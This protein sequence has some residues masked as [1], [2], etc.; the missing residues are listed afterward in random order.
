MPE[1][2]SEEIG[3]LCEQYYSY[4]EFDAK[5]LEEIRNRESEIEWLL[6]KYHM[7]SVSD[8]VNY[9]ENIKNQIFNEFGEF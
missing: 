6:K 5:R 8:L 1:Y 9:K 7:E 2:S 3:K 4:L